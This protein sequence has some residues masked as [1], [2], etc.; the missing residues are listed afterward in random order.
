MNVIVATKKKDPDNPMSF[1]IDNVLR[2][3]IVGVGLIDST[4]P[5]ISSKVKVTCHGDFSQIDG[6]KPGVGYLM[7]D[8][9]VQQNHRSCYPGYHGITCDFT[10]I[11]TTDEFKKIKEKT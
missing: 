6:D 10:I 9:E 7:A 2:G 1:D 11:M 5:D 4:S 3:D 8:E